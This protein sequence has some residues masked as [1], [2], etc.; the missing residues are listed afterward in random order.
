MLRLKNLRG[1]SVGEKV[2]DAGLI[3]LKELE[4]LPGGRALEGGTK[5]A[6]PFNFANYS[7]YVLL[8]K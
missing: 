1:R 6:C 8:V 3:I 7:I 5:E 4:E 2:T